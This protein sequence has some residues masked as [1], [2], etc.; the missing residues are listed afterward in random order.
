MRHFSLAAGSARRVAFAG[1]GSSLA[2]GLMAALMPAS[3]AAP[4]VAT[5]PTRPASGT[6]SA[7]AVSRLTGAEAA[8]RDGTSLGA[9]E[10]ILA[11]LSSSTTGAT[12]GR[13]STTG[14]GELTGVVH[15]AGGPIAQI[16]ITA[17]GSAGTITARVPATG[18]YLLSGLRPGH[19]QLQLARCAGHAGAPSGLSGALWPGQH[20]VT[21]RA[22]QLQ[23]LPAAIWWQVSPSSLARAG[24]P[25][26]PGAASKDGSISGLVTGGGKPVGGICALAFP[27]G[28]PGL[29]IAVTGKDGTYRT[30]LRP[31][32]YLMLFTTGLNR[33][34][35]HANW[36][37]Q[38]YPGINSPAKIR[39][40]KPI[41]V[42]AEKV[43]S[44]IDAKLK[45]G[46]EITGTVHSASGHPLS[47]ICVELAGPA[48]FEDPSNDRA[49][50]GT[51][52]RY[53]LHS[54]TQGNYR[55]VLIDCGTSNY[56]Y[57]WWKGATSR[58]QASIIKVTGPQLKKINATLAPGATVSGT[59]RALNASGEPISGVCV[60]AFASDGHSYAFR[61]TSKQGSYQLKGLAAG[62]YRLAFDP[63]R[64]GQGKH[65]STER[66]VSLATAQVVTGLD[67]YL[68]PGGG[69]SG[70]VTN[71]HGKPVSGVCVYLQN[72]HDNGAVTNASG[73]YTISGVAT[74]DYPVQFNGGCGSTGSLAPQYYPGQ[75]YRQFG[76]RVQIKPDTITPNIDATMQP[77]G[78]IAGTLTDTQGRRISGACMATSDSF[79][80]LRE[81]PVVNGKY[82]IVNLAPGPYNVSFGC[83]HYGVQL[84]RSQSSPLGATIVAVPPGA[85]TRISAR[86][87]PASAITGTVT[88]A[89][90]KPLADECVEVST[91][92]SGASAPFK[93]AITKHDG[94]Y[95]LAGLRA[96]RYLIQFAACGL[97]S[98]YGQQWYRDKLT[99][100]KATAVTLLPGRTIAGVDAKLA[101]AGS[102]TGLI[103]GPSDKPVS[104]EC[105]VAQDPAEH[106]VGQSRT[107]RSGRYTI[108]GLSPGSYY[109]Y[110]EPCGSNQRN[111]AQVRRPE[112]VMVAAGH[113]T[114][115]ANVKVPRGGSVAGLLVGGPAGE[116]PQGQVCV[117]VLPVNP[118]GSEGLGFTGR[119]GRY[120]INA[121]APGRYRAYLSDQA[122]DSLAS[123]GSPFAP[124]WYHDQ[125]GAGAATT[126]RVSAGTTTTGIDGTLQTF[127][128]LTGS[129]GTGTKPVVG[130]CVTAYP[131]GIAADPLL[132]TP[133]QAE[134]AVTGAAGSYALP[135]LSPGR[136]K[137]EFGTGCGAK[138]FATQWW[139]GASSVAAATPIRI[140]F[141]T[142]T[143]V[144]AVLRR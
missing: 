125:A 12:L 144:N 140:K 60:N 129:V 16:C 3:Q 137:V 76:Q 40:L 84:F 51:S 101:P 141:A 79:L 54:L 105:L 122:C 111:L 48:G 67:V 135:D 7:A 132:G 58:R 115:G 63:C 106:S 133:V 18:R 124:E 142:R 45:Q 107:S 108:D 36:L 41:K 34:P 112:R 37:T 83:P 62:T 10:R 23:T 134:L 110:A 39:H 80:G 11:S 109:L 86:L 139:H 136:Y 82:Q 65:L 26:A 27:F 102:I 74:G 9:Y 5:A 77:G 72:N 100:A 28:R 59:V 104:S 120:R 53:A 57:Q 61:V 95:R 103:T 21:V 19:Y 119:S 71:A 69:I 15:A 123:T 116:A 46:A 43:T 85:V 50:T 52:G 96:G 92:A 93:L 49:R 35:S 130:E 91:A 88:G 75:S 97:A 118:N 32:K 114:T 98:Q 25:A 2:I 138:G 89:G 128:G 14:T 56:A 44:G 121:L 29:H 127:G 47:K 64:T 30:R 70:L 8:L 22:G 17:T 78:T 24:R 87:S 38:L 81:A 20:G 1:I 131:F 31:G 117:L 4:M 126:F 33:C 99:A 94:S 55:M 143:G 113:L 13:S 6:P 90:G 68:Q 66:T 42:R 73:K